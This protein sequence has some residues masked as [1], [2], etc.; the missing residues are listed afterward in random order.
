MS[1]SPSSSPRPSCCPRLLWSLS[2]QPAPPEDAFSK[3]AA[4]LKVADERAAK[5][6]DQTYTASMEIFKS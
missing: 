6:P 4:I 5:F 2:R 3:G 1:Q